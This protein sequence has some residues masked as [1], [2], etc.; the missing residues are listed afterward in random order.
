M[1][2]CKGICTRYKAKRGSTKLGW[3]RQGFKRCQL[4]EIF[5][6]WN[7]GLHCPCCGSRLRTKPRNRKY[8][9]QLREQLTQ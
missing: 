6:K 2:G 8:K 1:P 9:E 3:Y 7:D 5:I 4:C